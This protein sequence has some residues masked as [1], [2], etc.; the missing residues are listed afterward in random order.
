MIDWSEFVATIRE[1]RRFIV[2]THIRPDCD[3]L[4]SSLAMARILESLD[5]EVLLC[6]AFT[7]PPNYRFL[8]L[9]G[10]FKQIGSD[11]SI[12]QLDS[13]DALIVVDTTAWAQLGPMGDAM[14]QAKLKKIVI[15][16]HVSGDDL[17]AV[18]FK[19]TSA[20]ATGR[21]MIEA[22]DALGVALSSPIAEAAYIALATDTGWFRF[23]STKAETLRLAARL[24]DAGAVP[25]K[26][27]RDLYE[28][29]R[30]GRLRLMGRAMSKVQIEKEGRLIYTWLDLADFDAA[31]AAPSD[32][33]DLINMTLSVSGTEAAVIF[34][35]QRGGAIKVS[36]RSRS[37]LDCAR[38]AEQFGGGGHKKAAGA[39]IVAPMETARSRAL[40]AV[41]AAMG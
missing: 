11:V 31:E 22:A 7:V 25:D 34:V 21:L 26:I 3:A 20:E 29:E 6:N 18:L 15:D 32:S 37:T 13:Y 4:G 40:D 12:E 2:S 38:L 35:E 1:G 23:S 30:L 41:R 27:Y 36:F 19:D 9:D 39:T 28:N 14:R 17:G 10:R 16:H 5:K 24:V 8:D 33:E